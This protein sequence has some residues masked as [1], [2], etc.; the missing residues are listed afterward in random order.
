MRL[1]TPILSYNIFVYKKNPEIILFVVAHGR[2]I[3]LL[4]QHCYAIIYSWFMKEKIQEKKY[5][6]KKYKIER[7]IISMK[8]H[9]YL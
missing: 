6:R 7:K 3:G 2:Y 1:N 9:K 8:L 4:K 5:I